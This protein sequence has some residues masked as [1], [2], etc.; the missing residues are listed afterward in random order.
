LSTSCRREAKSRGSEI[1]KQ[2]ELAKLVR[3]VK[4]AGIDIGQ[5][6]VVAEGVFFHSRKYAELF[7]EKHDK[8]LVRVD[9]QVSGW[10]ARNKR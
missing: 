7:A 3:Q 5:C 9:G 10:L 1:G 4:D 2:D 6:C 8:D